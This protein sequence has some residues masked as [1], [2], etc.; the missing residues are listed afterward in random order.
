MEYDFRIKKINA[1]EEVEFH[2]KGV[3]INYAKS[4][5]KIL[6]SLLTAATMKITRNIIVNLRPSFCER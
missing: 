5:E 1:K 3:A 4:K 2:D 6:T